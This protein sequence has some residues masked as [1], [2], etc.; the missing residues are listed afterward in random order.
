METSLETCGLLPKVTTLPK[1][2]ATRK[3][4]QKNGRAYQRVYPWQ[5]GHLDNQDPPFSVLS[6]RR[7]WP[8]RDKLAEMISDFITL[9]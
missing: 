6:S 2:S 5:L 4:N 1:S 8:Y 3:S 7:V 9:E